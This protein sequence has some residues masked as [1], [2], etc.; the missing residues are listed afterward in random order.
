MALLLYRGSPP[1]D[2]RSW[3]LI[4]ASH[5]LTADW[6]RRLDREQHRDAR[7]TASGSRHQPSSPRSMHRNHLY[8]QNG[9]SRRLSIFRPASAKELTISLRLCL[10]SYTVVCESGISRLMSVYVYSS[11][12][13]CR[14]VRA[15]VRAPELDPSA[16]FIKHVSEG[17]RLHNQECPAVFKE[18]SDDLRPLV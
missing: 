8:T 18:V 15:E 4:T 3:Q 7:R 17:V 1:T 14:R 13:F 5:V 2:N 9:N 10:H 16:L 12:Y 6:L 11:Q